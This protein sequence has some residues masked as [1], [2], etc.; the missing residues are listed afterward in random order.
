MQGRYCELHV[1][2][3]DAEIADRGLSY[4]GRHENMKEQYLIT[5]GEYVKRAIYEGRYIWFMYGTMLYRFDVNQN[6]WKKM[7]ILPEAYGLGL[8]I[9]FNLI[10]NGKHIFVYSSLKNRCSYSC[11]Q[12]NITNIYNLI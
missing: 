9:V 3:S 4:F 5:E 1:D 12:W 10:F 6:E 2:K 7:A 8:K 11:F